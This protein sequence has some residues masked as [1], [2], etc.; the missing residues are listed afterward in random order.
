MS[1]CIF[2]KIAKGQIPAD[3]VYEDDHCVAFKDIHPKAPVHVLLI[4]KKHI[5]SLA[6]AGAE[7]RVLL[8]YLNLKL[9]EIAKGQGI[10]DGFKIQV[11]TGAKGGQEVFHLHYHILG[12]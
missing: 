8:G 7:D 9:A 1:D 2:C 12:G 4:P 3:K 6:H 5:D 10:G 11:H